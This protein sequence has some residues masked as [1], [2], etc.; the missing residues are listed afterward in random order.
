MMSVLIAMYFSALE[1]DGIYWIERQPQKSDMAK[2]NLTRAAF[3]AA[4]LLVFVHIEPKNIMRISRGA[5]AP[6]NTFYV[7]PTPLT[8]KI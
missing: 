8:R 2:K 3:D 1:V 5:R 6:H 4:R 7:L